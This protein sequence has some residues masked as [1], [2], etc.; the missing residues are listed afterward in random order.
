MA[1]SETNTS[2]LGHSKRIHADFVVAG[3]NPSVTLQFTEESLN[4]VPLFV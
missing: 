2:Q 3:C 1:E 4:V